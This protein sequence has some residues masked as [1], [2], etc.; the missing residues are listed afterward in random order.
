MS[1]MNKMHLSLNVHRAKKIV[2][3]RRDINSFWSYDFRVIDDSNNSF[4]LQAFVDL[5]DMNAFDADLREAVDTAVVQL[6]TARI[7]IDETKKEKS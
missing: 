4:K 5:P 1:K 6:N 2:V 3:E 7:M